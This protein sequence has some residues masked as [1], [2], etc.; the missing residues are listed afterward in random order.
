MRYMHG[1]SPL[2]CYTAMLASWYVALVQRGSDIAKHIQELQVLHLDNI[3]LTH[4][5]H[6]LEARLLYYQSLLHG[7]ELSVKFIETTPNPAMDSRAT[8][9]E[10]RHSDALMKKE[11]K[12]LLDEIDRL[13]RR[14][15]M[16]SS[17]LKNA[18]ELVFAIVNTEDSRRMQRFSYLTLVFLPAGFTAVSIEVLRADPF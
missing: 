7:F 6:V 18:M 16:L 5:L 3:S 10:R 1:M 4:D 2:I 13:E 11:C 15:M 17:R 8:G 12:N 9:E 14:R